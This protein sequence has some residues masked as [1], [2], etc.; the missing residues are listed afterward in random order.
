M[1]AKKPDSRFPYHRIVA[2]QFERESVAGKVVLVGVTDPAVR[3]VFSTAI[4]GRLAMP[5]VEVQ[6]NALENLLAG[7]RV[8]VAGGRSPGPPQG[9]P[10]RRRQRDLRPCRVREAQ[11]GTPASLIHCSAAMPTLVADCPRCDSRKMTFDVRAAKIIEPRRYGWQNFYETFCICRHC[12][13]AT[14]FVLSERSY[15]TARDLKEAGG[16]FKLEEAANNYLDVNG[17]V[18]LKDK[19]TA[20]PPEHVPDDIAAVFREG[21][22][23]FAVGCYNAAGTMFRLCVDLA[24]RSMLPA[25]EEEA[26]GLNATIRRNLGLRLPWLF[27][28]GRL[29]LDLKALS[30]CIKDDGNDG[31]HAGTLKR[32]DAEDLL[33]FTT[34]LL[35]RIY[36]EPQRLR[37]AEERRAARRD[38]PKTPEGDGR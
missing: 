28:N 35:E 34:A 26:P 16:L 18:S 9:A 21:A 36:T 25:P 37:S 33:D 3:D 20:A 22:T 6:A 19:A 15:S 12:G 11:L 4:D 24:T 38:K 31:A 10:Q 30:S 23:C 14:I 17:Y 2:G 8:Q 1:S 13:R 32:E 29:P 5:G 7:T 27:D